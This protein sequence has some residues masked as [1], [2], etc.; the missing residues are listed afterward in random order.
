LNM[1]KDTHKKKMLKETIYSLRIIISIIIIFVCKMY[2]TSKL[3]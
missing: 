1:L 3:Q 2:S